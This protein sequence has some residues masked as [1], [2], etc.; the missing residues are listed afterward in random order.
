MLTT[1]SHSISFS[2][3]TITLELTVPSSYQGTKGK[4]PIAAKNCG[5]TPT[6]PAQDQLACIFVP[7]DFA[8]KKSLLLAH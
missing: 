7:S 3:V 6:H 2:N 8:P 1:G 5:N 4:N